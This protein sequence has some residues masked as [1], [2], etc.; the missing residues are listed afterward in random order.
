M[1]ASDNNLVV[2]SH[3]PGRIRLHVPWGMAEGRG[4]I[5]NRIH[6]IDGVQR[7]QVN[8]LTGNVLVH[9]DHRFMNQKVLLA[10]MTAILEELSNEKSPGLDS[11]ST[12]TPPADAACSPARFVVSGLLGHAI[13]DSLWFGA[14]FLG[15]AMGLPLAGL[16]PLH[17]LMDIVVWVNA[18]SGE[19]GLNHVPSE[20]QRSGRVALLPA[21]RSTRLE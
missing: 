3:V 5:Q 9:F 17:V 19:P 4:F 10:K 21:D 16:G 11:R 6:R 12:I 20:K 15:S 2:L 13:V 7:V 18:L 14:G 1:I 8:P